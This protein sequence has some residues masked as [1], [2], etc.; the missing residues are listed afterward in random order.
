MMR[1]AYQW[2]SWMNMLAG[3][4]MNTRLNL[5]LRERHGWVYGVEAAASTL[6]DTGWWRFGF[7]SDL[8][9][10]NLHCK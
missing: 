8:T 2:L 6:S 1:G 3:A 10:Q 9:T 5:L 7:G 4:G